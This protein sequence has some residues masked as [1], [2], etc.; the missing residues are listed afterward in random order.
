MPHALKTIRL[1]AAEALVRFLVA[2]KVETPSGKVPLFGGVFAVFGHGNVVGLGET[3]YRYRELLPTYRAHNEQAM[4]HTAIAY[5][6]AHFRRRM[7]AVTS[8]IGPGATNMVTAAAT[9]HVNRLPLLLLPGDVFA[10][11]AP[12]PVLQQVEDFAD[13]TLSASDCFRP[14]SRYFDRI[15]RPEQLVKALPQALHVLTDPALCGPVTLSLP[16]D[17]QTMAFD[18]PDELFREKTVRFRAPPPDE[19]ELAEAV[20]VLRG[21]KRP[22]IIAGGGVLYAEG[23]DALRAFAETHGV[24]VAETMGG[25]SA[26]PWD[27][28]LQAGT[29]GHTGGP[30]AN[31]LAREADVVLA[32]GTRLNDF[33]TGSHSLFPQAQ[34]IGLNVNGFDAV[35]WHALPLVAD[36]RLGLDALRSRLEGF[37]A[38]PAWTSKTRQLSDAWREAVQGLTSRKDV[39]LPYDAD[40]IGAVQ[41]TARRSPVEDIVV[42]AGGTI[43]NELEKLWRAGVPGG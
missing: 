24:P 16:Q 42:T 26:L 40:V 43:P 25:K 17:V 21:A 8:S 15:M 39:K 23:W 22:L 20:Q 14:V 36:A 7:M 11:R 1:T 19:G 35:K 9:A 4:A 34:L 12:D 3:L 27:H 30:A 33:S 41:R 18:F 32:V 10:S 13:G 6:K 37:R 2:H 29:I 31:E 28:P 5:A 38:D